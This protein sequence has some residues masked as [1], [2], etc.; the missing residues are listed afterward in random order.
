MHK[1]V[2][3]EVQRGPRRGGSW[4]FYEKEEGGKTGS[5]RLINWGDGQW[6][7]KRL[8]EKEMG[9]GD[10]PHTMKCLALLAPAPVHTLTSP[11]TKLQ[12]E[13]QPL[14]AGSWVGFLWGNQS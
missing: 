10:Q 13:Y 6:G 12:V 2:E 7:K 4:R 9:G 14:N 11:H 3:R 8:G 1:R 5:K